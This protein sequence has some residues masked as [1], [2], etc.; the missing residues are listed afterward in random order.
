MPHAI[1]SNGSCKFVISFGPKTL[2]PPP[3]CMKCGAPLLKAC[4]HCQKPIAQEPCATGEKC[5]ECG[6][7]F[8]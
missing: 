3:V 5:A 7:S 8:W 1:C 2:P 6:Q 4:P